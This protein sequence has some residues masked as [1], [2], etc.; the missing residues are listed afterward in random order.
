VNAAELR[1]QT[2]QELSERLIE[3]QEEVFN[4]RFQLA[5]HRQLDNPLAIRAARREIARIR[6]LLGED[7]RGAYQLPRSEA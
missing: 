1:Q 3:L 4:L 5:A 6:T 7:D 2:R